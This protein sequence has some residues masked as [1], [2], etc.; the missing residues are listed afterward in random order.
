MHLL[1][2]FNTLF[3]YIDDIVAKVRVIYIDR[4]CGEKP[5][6]RSIYVGIV[7]QP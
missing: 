1:V 7:L 3:F 5:Q 6:P 2:L 4:G